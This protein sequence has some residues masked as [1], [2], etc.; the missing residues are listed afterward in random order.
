MA[1]VKGP[2][3][4]TLLKSTL[5]SAFRA[6]AH[7]QQERAALIVYES[8]ARFSYKELLEKTDRTANGLY[9]LGLRKGDRLGV[10]M[11]NNAEWL[12]LQ[13]ATAKLGV[14]LVA[15]NPAYRLR[16]LKYA[17][18]LVGCKAIALVERAATSNYVEM[19]QALCPEMKNGSTTIESQDVPAL[20]HVILVGEGQFPAMIPFESLYK[21][22]ETVEAAESPD[23]PINIQ[24][25][26]GTTGYPKA[27]TL[28]HTGILNNGYYVG[29]ACHLTAEDILCV[30]VPLYHCFGCVMANL[31]MVT[32]GC[33]M[34]YPSGRFDPLMTLKAAIEHRC[35]SL[36]GVPTMWMA[37]LDHPE[38][39]KYK[40]E[41]LRTGIMAGALCPEDTMRRVIDEMGAKE[42][43][44]AYGMTETSPVS[45][46]V[47]IGTPLNLVCTTV[48]QII[49]HTECKVVDPETCE[50]LPYDTPGELWTAGFPVMQGYWENPEANKSAIIVQDGKRWMRTGDLAEIDSDGFC[51]IVGRI[52]DMILRGGENIFPKEVEEPLISHPN[53]SNASVIGV[54][55]QLLGEQVCAWISWKGGAPEGEAAREAEQ[56]I[57]TY[58]KD[59][60]AHFKVP[61]YI[62][63]KD[64]F[65]MTVTGKIRKI[66]MREISTK[67]LG[68]NSK[69]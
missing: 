66:D 9:D 54:P 38:F 48:G 16:E 13:L 18:N 34:V 5:Y 21:D 3:D 1:H 33:T 37:V 65:P 30:P 53:I 19:V 10:W 14:I 24:F 39:K 55:D 45:W 25:T 64:E 12:L 43:T 52:K 20:K 36:Y 11:P 31:A 56:S 35:T 62:C 8:G 7:Q 49:P 63:F 26:S 40:W 67:E 51:R 4:V 44:I 59:Q 61:K 58:L 50:V 29:A 2:E 47:R 23:E 69:L 6:Q 41:A 15:L 27:S 42:V 28:T 68:L 22:G 60:V 57:R 46:Q 32:H 17:L